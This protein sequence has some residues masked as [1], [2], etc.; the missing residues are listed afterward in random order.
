[1]WTLL[2]IAHIL[3]KRLCGVEPASLESVAVQ[4]WTI[5]PAEVAI[6]RQAYFLPG[7]L[8]RITGWAFAS[9]HPRNYMQG[10][11][12]T[13]AATM[14][15]LLHDAWLI[16]GVLYKGMGCSHLKPRSKGMLKLTVDIELDRCAVYCTYEANKYFGHWLMDDCLTYQLAVD[17]GSPITTD[18]AVTKHIPDYETLLG[19]NPMRLG[20][21][22][23]RDLIIFNDRGDN[24]SKRQR[25]SAHRK[26]LLSNLVVEPHPGVFI[27]RGQT[28]E[29]RLLCN[30][31]ELASLLQRKRGL[32]IIDPANE[33]VPTIVRTC[34]GAR[35]V[36]GVEG[37]GL[38]HGIQLLSAGNAVL[39][40]QPP[41]RFVKTYKHLT[42]REGMHFGFVV[43]HPEKGG[44]RVDPAEIEQTL[45]L[46]PT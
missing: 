8:E 1:M 10:A 34:A 33:D 16:D 2:P 9:E 40:L 20:S 17:E 15:Y 5:A 44:F 32:R 27:L 25:F 45:D 38:I 4:S 31:M 46:F 29:S 24:I 7:Q 18:Q 13:H 22:H 37:S 12:G 42:D 43:G 28:G 26:R 19:M 41:N 3:R 36:V 30:E 11:S 21:A 23:F 14:A 6:S 35:V 39:T